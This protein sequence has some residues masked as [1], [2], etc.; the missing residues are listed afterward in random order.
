MRTRKE[1][2]EDKEMAT[3]FDVKIFSRE[4]DFGLWKI[5][6]V[7][8]ACGGAQEISNNTLQWLQGEHKKQFQTWKPTRSTL[9][10][11][12]KNHQESTQNM[13]N[14]IKNNKEGTLQ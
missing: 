13:K 4:N 5:K 14:N 10:R 2:Q 3:K 8:T 12:K 6:M 11:E 7:D 9:K 1:S